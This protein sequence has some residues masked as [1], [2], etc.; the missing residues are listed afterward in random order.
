MHVGY[1]RAAPAFAAAP[2]T[3]GQERLPDGA[4]LATKVIA[5]DPPM[6]RWQI[7]AR[8]PVACGGTKRGSSGPGRIRRISMLHASLPVLRFKLKEAFLFFGA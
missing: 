3:G 8:G 4:D 1:G 7:G 6:A 2:E 5:A